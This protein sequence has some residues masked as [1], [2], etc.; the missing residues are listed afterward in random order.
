MEGAQMADQFAD[1]R[2]AWLFRVLAHDKLI[3]S[4]KAVAA[5]LALRFNREA[6][7][8]A[9]PSL[10]KI[11]HDVHISRS[12]AAK[13]IDSL[14]AHGFIEVKSGGG[15][16]SPHEGI[17]NRYRM[18]QSD[19][20]D[21]NGALPSDPPDCKSELPSDLGGSYRPAHRTQTPERTPDIDSL[22]ERGV[23]KSS[24]RRRPATSPPESI[25]EQMLEYAV[26]KASWN[27]AKAA[28]EFQNFRD[29]HL[30]KGNRFAD[31]EAAW[32]TW[33]RRGVEYEGQR[34]QQNGPIID[35]GGNPVS[36][37]PNQQ[38]RQRSHRKS[39][40]ELAMQMVV[41]GDDE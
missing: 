33:V 21:G 18:L 37:P 5:Y 26:E 23:S 36:P 29:H 7:G 30:K 2:D 8:V 6:G 31:W 39:N 15:R 32:R 40:T 3:A 22:S 11:A 25:S 4:E 41:E 28:S 13:A 27:S 10:E 34:A 14:K 17:S 38:Q 1:A 16:R 9:W 12:T 35:Q 20:P 19:P 24:S